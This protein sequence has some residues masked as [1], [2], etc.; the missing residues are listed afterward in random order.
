[1]LL[2][3]LYLIAPTSDAQVQHSTSMSLLPHP[4]LPHTTAH[5]TTVCQISLILYRVAVGIDE[6]ENL[7][8]KRRIELN[9]LLIEQVFEEAYTTLSNTIVQWGDDDITIQYVSFFLR[10]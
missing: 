7:D 1:M 8:R 9:K 10:T 3:L 2:Y 6:D 4:H 5:N